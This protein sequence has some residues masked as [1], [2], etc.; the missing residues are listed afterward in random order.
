[1][2]LKHLRNK[3]RRNSIKNREI[4]PDEIF[5]DSTNLPEFNTDQFEGR[6]ER[7]ISKMSLIAVGIVFFIIIIVFGWKIWS[8][9]VSQGKSFASISENNRLDNS[10]IFADRGVVYDRNNT[11]LI[12]NS[13]TEKDDFSH[14]KYIEL[15]G[16][17]HT[18]GYVSYPLKDDSGVY[19]QEEF[20]PKAGVEK[21][22]NQVLNGSSGLRIIE[23]NALM[24]IQSESV[25]LEAKGGENITLSIDARVQSKMYELIEALVDE[26]GFDGGT[27]VISNI[28][29]GEVLSMTSFPEYSSQ[30]L[31]DGEP[32]EKISGYAQN[33]NNPYL[34]RATSGLYTPGSTV[35]LFVSLGALNEKLITPEKQ[36]L[37]TGSISIPNPYYPDKESVFVDWKAH[38]LVDMRDAIA[39][40][41]NVYFYEIG[42][43]FE[44]QKGLGIKNIEKYM[45]MFGFGE[46][47]NIYPNE[48]LDEKNGVIPNPE[49]KEENFDGDE[50]RIGDT[51]HTA[52]GQYGFQVTAL[53]LARA[54]GAIANGGKLYKP[55]L[56]LGDG[57]QSDRASVRNKH[58][59]IVREG[60]RQA[61]TD[62]TAKGLYI[63]QVK[64]AAKTGTAQLGTTKTYVNSL[65][66]GFFP[67]DNPK[68]AFTVI[69]EKGKQSNTIGALFIM[70][71]LLE[72]MAENTPEYLE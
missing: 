70:R 40:S 7:P 65:V 15:K 16:L 46:K 45:R 5:I 59:P 60:M 2:V 24:E 71:Q 39:V 31:S 69:M 55:T 11:E 18:L 34:N 64:V 8:L 9:Q 30:V 23:T 67:Y 3:R 54:V 48:I 22:Y 19:Y 1:M 17:S 14:R 53:Q 57:G 12:W 52:I 66:V 51:Y 37:S 58:Y 41:S 35:K 63:P 28:N 50:W 4:E 32:K 13:K 26:I 20:I 36:I 21:L 47:T 38:G 56:I 42:G 62:G 10:I 6:I 27:G 44:D 68:Y 29:N 49:W 61:V 43:G 72:W 25:T 33:K